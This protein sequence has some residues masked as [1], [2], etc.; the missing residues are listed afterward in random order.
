M[1]I[2]KVIGFAI[3]TSLLFGGLT[4]LSFAQP[5]NEII[6]EEQEEDTSIENGPSTGSGT[7]DITTGSTDDT[8]ALEKKP[9]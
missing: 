4:A 9:L 8:P 7:T 1:K 6:V 5:Q 2:K 3:A